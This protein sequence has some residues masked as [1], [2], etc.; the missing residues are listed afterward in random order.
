MAEEPPAAISEGAD[1]TYFVVEPSR[2][3]L[4]E[5]AGLVD[6]GALRPVID[7]VFPLSDAG[8]A[9]QRVMEPG[10]R[11]KV[12]LRVRDSSSG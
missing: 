2:A 8:A 3:Q 6:A 7:S 10:K 4:I 11:G 5:L 1:T 9:F 12:V